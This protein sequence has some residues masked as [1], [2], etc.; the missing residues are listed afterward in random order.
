MKIPWRVWS[1]SV[2]ARSLT[3]TVGNLRDCILL[4]VHIVSCIIVFTLTRAQSR[5]RARSEAAVSRSTRDHL[6]RLIIVSCMAIG[7]LPCRENE[8]YNVKLIQIALGSGWDRAE[9]IATLKLKLV[10]KNF[11]YHIPCKIWPSMFQTFD[12]KF[13]LAVTSDVAKFSYTL[14]LI[15]KLK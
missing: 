6:V 9:L 4:Q 7:R 5:K 11:Q 14:H 1:A 13:I 15:L 10:T 12:I 3:H 2:N 8:L